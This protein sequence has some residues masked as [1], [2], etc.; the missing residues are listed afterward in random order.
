[1]SKTLDILSKDFGY[2]WQELNGYI[3]I[4]TK[5]DNFLFDSADMNNDHINLYH[6]NKLRK[7]NKHFQS[8]IDSLYG[9]FKYIKSH[10][11]KYYK[12]HFSTSKMDRLFAQIS[13]AK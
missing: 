4:S 9:V 2:N 6:I 3:Y 5:E 11:S 7:A 13:F 12:P 8:R 10:E 1:M